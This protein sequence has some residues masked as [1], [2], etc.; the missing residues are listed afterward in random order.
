VHNTVCQQIS[1]LQMYG[2]INM[3]SVGGINENVCCYDDW[4]LAGLLCTI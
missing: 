2:F 4:P 1:Q 3:F